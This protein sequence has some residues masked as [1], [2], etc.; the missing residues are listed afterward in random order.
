MMAA[1]DYYRA[2]QIATEGEKT[3]HGKF[4][5]DG[6][7][8]QDGLYTVN[9]RLNM[10]KNNMEKWGYKLTNNG[11]NCDRQVADDINSATFDISSNE[12]PI[13][14]FVSNFA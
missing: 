14:K 2:L 8:D 13:G 10:F 1:F 5:D 3:H 7:K 12:N 9:T 11:C 4:I 6:F